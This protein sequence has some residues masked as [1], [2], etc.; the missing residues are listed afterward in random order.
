MAGTEDLNP[1][2]ST[3]KSATADGLV[4]QS[5]TFSAQGSAGGASNS[6]V[7]VTESSLKMDMVTSGGKDPQRAKTPADERPRQIDIGS[8]WSK[9][10]NGIEEAA[11]NRGRE[12]NALKSLHDY[13]SVL[14]SAEM[15]EAD[16]LDALS[17]TL[18]LLSK[19]KDWDKPQWFK[20]Q[21]ATVRDA[22]GRLV[23][24][25]EL[26]QQRNGLTR[27]GMAMW[28]AWAAENGKPYAREAGAAQ[29][30]VIALDKYIV[31]RVALDSIKNWL[32]RRPAEGF[33][34]DMFAALA[35]N[36]LYLKE[37]VRLRCLK[38]ADGQVRAVENRDGKLFYE[39]SDQEIETQQ[40][41]HG[42]FVAMPD[43]SDMIVFEQRTIQGR[44]QIVPVAQPNGKDPN[45][46]W[47]SGAA[48]KRG[49]QKE[50]RFFSGP[51]SVTMEE[52]Y[53]FFP[54]HFPMRLTNSTENRVPTTKVGGAIYGYAKEH[55][56]RQARQ[57]IVEFGEVMP[58]LKRNNSQ[59]INDAR[60]LFGLQKPQGSSASGAPAQNRAPAAEVVTE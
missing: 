37:N 52:L 21:P 7:A 43:D 56:G 45:I 48:V 53:G 25:H 30:Q 39:G 58:G 60:Q 5:V 55:A 20:T 22:S 1:Y 49:W 2:E 24:E 13:L 32:R 10:K 57:L 16:Q 54:D 46:Q 19:I 36:K 59:L 15:S 27:E 14:K 41:E 4:V 35:Q 50:Q 17:Q 18:A 47:F 29:Q 11:Y 28:D 51:Q 26:V 38:D 40:D 31:R 33:V 9:A 6:S 42:T 23:S 34:N 12:A 8:A 3:A 44:R